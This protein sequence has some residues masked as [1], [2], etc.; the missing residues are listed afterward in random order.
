LRE[1]FGGTGYDE[2]R[3]AHGA[4]DFSKF[5]FCDGCDQL[6]KRE[7]VLVYTTI[8]NARVGATNTTYFE[9]QK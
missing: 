4:G 9:L 7:D 1:V 5:P 8:K 2:L 3:K 6:N